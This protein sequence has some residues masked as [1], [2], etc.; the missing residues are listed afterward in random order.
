MLA[1]AGTLVLANAGTLVLAN[2][3][4]GRRSWVEDVPATPLPFDPIKEAHRQWDLRW[5]E[6]AGE[7][8]AAATSIMRAQ[9]VVLA[10]VDDALRPFDLTFARYEALMLPLL[11]PERLPAARQD[12]P[13]A[14]DPPSERHQHREPTGTPG[15][16]PKGAPPDRQKDHLGRADRGGSPAGQAGDQ[17]VHAG[18][19]GLGS[20]NREDLE[21]IVQAVRRLRL[22]VGDFTEP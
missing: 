15:S 12:E 6:R 4:P 9:Q 19:F 14:D 20:L 11:H 8:M 18:D 10:A 7:S 5:D 13:A 1:N 16:G 3:A 2:A 21:A 17:A 22:G